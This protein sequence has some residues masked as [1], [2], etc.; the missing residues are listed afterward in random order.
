[1][2]SNN[3]KDK[4]KTKIDVN[5]SSTTKYECNRLDSITTNDT[6]KVKEL[7]NDIYRH[8][9]RTNSKIEVP[10]KSNQEDKNLVTLVQYSE[11]KTSK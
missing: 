8:E 3:K 7:R 9:L 2:S 4:N 11:R 10:I 5:Q 1:M 6:Y